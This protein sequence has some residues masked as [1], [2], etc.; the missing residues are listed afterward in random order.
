MSTPDSTDVLTA[1]RRR[2]A[3]IL[4]K[5][6]DHKDV[7]FDDGVLLDRLT[8]V[9]DN[10]VH[11]EYSIYYTSTGISLQRLAKGFDFDTDSFG[12][13]IDSPN[14]FSDFEKT[15]KEQIL[16]FNPTYSFCNKRETNSPTSP[17]EKEHGE[18]QTTPNE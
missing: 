3:E 10:D 18:N 8:I 11:Q 7:V 15:V 2:I 5:I 16:R 6:E 4:H 14:F 12:F 9:S 17:R 13:D 1:V